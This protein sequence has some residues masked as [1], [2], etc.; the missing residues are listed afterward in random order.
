MSHKP[1]AVNIKSPRE[2]ASRARGR[3]RGAPGA[4]PNF[5]DQTRVVPY[6]KRTF[7]FFGSWFNTGCQFYFRGGIAEFIHQENF[8]GRGI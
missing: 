6:Y 3:R 1:K 8:A 2:P 5:F 7:L 4:V